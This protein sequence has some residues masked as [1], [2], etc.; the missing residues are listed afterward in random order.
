MAEGPATQEQAAP[1]RAAV[2][3]TLQ[4]AERLKIVVLLATAYAALALLFGF[5][6]LYSADG[7][8]WVVW[9]FWSSPLAM[10]IAGL[11]ALGWIILR[12]LAD[13]SGGGPWHEPASPAM[14][15]YS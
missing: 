10:F 7:P 8:G 9:W 6:Q 11:A 2:D 14:D 15:H 4:Q 5:V 13:L 1:R 12:R 3:R